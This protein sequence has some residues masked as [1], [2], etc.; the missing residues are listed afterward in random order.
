MYFSFSHL[1]DFI[2]IELYNTS[3]WLQKPVKFLVV[4]VYF[5]CMPL[6]ENITCYLYI[7][8]L[9]DICAVV[10]ILEYISWCILALI[11]VGCMPVDLLSHGKYICLTY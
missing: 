4:I 5:I 8:L 3:D 7:L 11:S 9:I 6:N 10:N 1:W 2:E